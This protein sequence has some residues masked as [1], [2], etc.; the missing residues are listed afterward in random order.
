MTDQEYNLSVTKIE[1][2][3]KHLSFKHVEKLMEKIVMK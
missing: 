2:Y 1:K 3:K